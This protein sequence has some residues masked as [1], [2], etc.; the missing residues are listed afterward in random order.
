MSMP[1]SYLSTG[2]PS[3][4]RCARMKRKTFAFL[5]SAR[6]MA[7][8]L[9]YHRK[10]QAIN[11]NPQFNLNKPLEIEVRTDNNAQQGFNTE[12]PLELEVQGN[13]LILQGKQASAF[14]Y[15]DDREMHNDTE[16]I[17]MVRN[18]TLVDN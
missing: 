17:A 11:S 13:S 12:A 5:Q 6:R 10:Q 8:R 2:M 9:P 7:A 16:L 14:R 18:S 3:L 1:G 4:Q 15:L